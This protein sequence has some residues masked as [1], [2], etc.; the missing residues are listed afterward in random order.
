MKTLKPL[1]FFVLA[2]LAFSCISKDKGDVR[3]P[4]IKAFQKPPVPLMIDRGFTEYI[5]GYTSGVIPSR[6][7]IEIRFTPEFAAKCNKKAMPLFD[8]KPELRGK[9][10][11]KD[12]VTLVFTPARPLESGK[13]Y[14]GTLNLAR[15]ADVQ[16]RLSLFPIRIQAVKKDFRVTAGPPEATGT[17]SYKLSGEIS[18]SDIIDASETERFLKVKSGR[19]ELT[20]EWD[21][22]SELV[23]RFTVSGIE[24]KDKEEI[25][26]LQ[27][28]GQPGGVKQKGSLKVAIPRK[29][30]FRVLSIKHSGSQ[31]QKI[32]VV[33]S[34]PVD[35]EADNEGLFTFNPSSPAGISVN[36]NIVSLFPAVRFSSQV[37]LTVDMSVK[38]TEGLTLGS[39]VTKD[40][41]FSVV[42]PSI[43]LA[44]RGV[45]VPAS[46][47]LIFPF[48]AAS[49]KAVDLKIIKI[50][51]NNLP[52]FLQESDLDRGYG[53]KRFGRPV[54]SGRVDL[55]KTPDMSSTG[56][57]LHTI[58]LSDY[59]NVEPGVL[60]K[61]I[62][63]M[64]RSYSLYPCAGENSPGKYE[65]LLDRAA[66]LTQSFWDDPEGYFDDESDEIYYNSDFN[67]RDRDNPCL[68]AYYS[69]D[70]K[71]TGTILASNFGIIAKMGEDRIMNV[72][73][74][75]LITALPVNEASVE[76][77][78][79]Q[80]QPLAKGATS[81]EGTVA[82]RCERKPFLVIV[83][84]DK[85]R[86]YLR[87]NDG[88]SLSM[89]SFDVGGARP[90]K[91]I[92]AYV[93]GER[94]VWRPG[95]S[96]FLSVF[97]KDMKKELPSGHPVEFELFN[98]L[99]QRVDNQV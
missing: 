67:W 70:R 56:W 29:G 16:E 90:E 21:H 98:P 81:P 7:A 54:W 38:N 18:T 14:T 37:Q 65:E 63:G 1:S 55:V 22:S 47:N 48:R 52:Y 73:V 17:G 96:I 4:E 40:I 94:D 87:T 59:I 34:D 42:P 28:N 88:S 13:S 95:D 3:L 68:D 50:Y 25:L 36:S 53:L 20:P 44:G 57:N 23:H 78:D 83:K 71:V 58:D 30:D 93:F 79:Y 45:I 39:D 24:R 27:W 46:D 66:E 51:E 32:D 77:F 60:Y 9:T 19:K 82:L 43:E 35:A 11:W 84:K 6:A 8:F 15:M 33:F 76:L 26:E 10:E 91:G 72:I 62:L 12:E 2:I 64:R 89:S 97:V 41:D 74:S 31:D 80:L 99:D 69:P 49:L 5:S 86:N 61:V 92:K 85:D 75:D